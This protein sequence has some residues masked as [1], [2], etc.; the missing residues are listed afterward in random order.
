MKRNFKSFLSMKTITYIRYI[1]ISI[2]RIKNWFPFLLNYIGIKNDNFERIYRLRDGTKFKSVQSLDA[3]TIFVIYIRKDYG[4]VPDNSI[5]VDVGANIGVYTVYASLKG[6]N[7]KIISY[8]PM[9][10]NFDILNDNISLNNCQNNV[11]THNL[12]LASKKEKRKFYL[13]DAVEHSLI[14]R[15]NDSVDKFV[16]IETITLAD[17]FTQNSIEKIDLLKMDCEGAEYEIFYNTT[18]EI[19]K[20]VKEIR[21][22]FHGLKEGT[23]LKEFFE[24]KDFTINKFEKGNL[25]CTQ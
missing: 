1:P 11:I 10:D 19:L 18:D 4:N 24:K 22:E 2:F 17:V 8:E 6:N 7:N 15:G 23:E 3:A 21:M 5:I 25:W 16:E 13:S 12:A 20:K 9:K 14:P